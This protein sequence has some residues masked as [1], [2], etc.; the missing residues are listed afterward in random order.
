MLQSMTGS[1]VLLS[2]LAVVLAI[3]LTGMFTVRTSTIWRTAQ[4]AASV[5]ERLDSFMREQKVKD[6]SF[7]VEINGLNQT[8]YSSRDTPAPPVIR[9]SYIERWMENLN[10]ELRAKLDAANTRISLLERRVR[11]LEQQR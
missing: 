9:P 2:G 8:L 3:V 1:K 11:E 5:E 7:G 6:D 10:K 4:K